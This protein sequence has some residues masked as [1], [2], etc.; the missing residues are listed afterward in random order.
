M[1]ELIYAK[2]IDKEIGFGVFA[3]KD[4]EKDVVIG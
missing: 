3:L 4:L 1:D 2:F